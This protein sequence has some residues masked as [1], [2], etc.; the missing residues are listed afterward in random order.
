[1]TALKVVVGRAETTLHNRQL[2]PGLRYIDLLGIIGHAWS[3][4]RAESGL[5]TSVL[6]CDR[7]GGSRPIGPAQDAIGDDPA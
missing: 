6:D 1:M 4:A 2:S 7:A 3:V 5:D